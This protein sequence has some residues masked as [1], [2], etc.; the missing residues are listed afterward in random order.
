MAGEGRPGRRRLALPD[1]R[2]RPRVPVPEQHRAVG[3]PRGD[4]AVRGDVALAPRQARHHAVVAEHDLHDLGC[5]SNVDRGQ[6]CR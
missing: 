1:D 2:L 4:V 5:N 3:A 6:M